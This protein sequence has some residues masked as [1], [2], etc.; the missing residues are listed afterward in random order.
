[1]A[2][3]TQPPPPMNEE[4]E[5]EEDPVPKAAVAKSKRRKS[6]MPALNSSVAA[7]LLE[8]LP[9]RKLVA[10]NKTS[11][12]PT[13]KSKTP[14]KRPPKPG[15]SGSDKN[16]IFMVHGD[17]ILTFKN[18]DLT[19]NIKDLK[20]FNL[21][22]IST[23]SDWINYD[24]FNAVQSLV[25]INKRHALETY[26]IAIKCDELEFLV[27]IKSSLL[28]R[29][30]KHVQTLV[31]SVKPNPKPADHKLSETTGFYLLAYI[32]PGCTQE[33][34]KLPG[35]MVREGF[36]TGIH[37]DTRED[38]ENLMIQI[39]TEEKD[40][41]LEMNGGK[42]KSELG[43]AAQKLARFGVIIDSNEDHL[44]DLGEKAAKI[45]VYHDKNFRDIDGDIIHLKQDN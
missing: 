30:T 8:T 14:E 41:I 20:G 7:P 39:L 44:Y 3:P 12:T 25:K 21:T 26:L 42:D 34:S 36:G 22:V 29:Y 9:K 38:V 32:F 31:T 33:D 18:E 40:W 45:A 27:D 4:E 37:G 5:N 1:M 19:E 43:L 15:Y 28:S 6:M 13:K 35:P 23:Q 17:P 16:D 11:S 10:E 24:V 2:L